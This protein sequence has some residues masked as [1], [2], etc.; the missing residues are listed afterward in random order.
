M[1]TVDP[2]AA[3]LKVTEPVLR[4]LVG[5]TS[6]GLALRSRRTAEHPPP[7]VTPPE[8]FAGLWNWPYEPRYV[9]VEPGGY[10]MAYVQEG[11]DDGPVALLVHGN[12]AWGYYYRH[13]V[14]PLAQAG[15]R[16]VVPDLVGFGRSD[17]PSTRSAHT[18]DNHERWLL[19]LIEQLDLTGVNAHLHDWGGLL[20]LRVVAFSPHRFARVL[21]SNTALPLGDGG[22]VP[23]LF[24][25]WQLLAQ[26]VPNFGRVLDAASATTLPPSVVAAYDAPFPDHASAYGPRQLPLEVPLRPGDPGA[27]RN[28]EAL[29][30]LRRFDKPF[31]TAFSVPDDI[32]TGA[33]EMLQAAV[34]GARPEVLGRDHPTFPDTL[35]YLMEDAP[36]ELTSLMLEFFAGR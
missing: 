23:P 3:A 27:R 9:T 17:K 14:A 6:R 28:R 12:P 33:A 10:R 8:R 21:V 7:R 19:R 22:P 34:P 16:V 30:A 31:L 24:R 15:F 25:R 18:Y 29:A 36:A 1:T 26:V 11:P 4:G 35:H 13:A 2:R 20:G 32:T 5:V